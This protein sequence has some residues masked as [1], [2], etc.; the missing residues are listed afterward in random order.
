MVLKRKLTDKQKPAWVAE[1]TKYRRAEFKGI[2]LVLP[3]GFLCYDCIPPETRIGDLARQYDDGEVEVWQEYSFGWTGAP[4]CNECQ[5]AIPVYV[6][7]SGM[8]GIVSNGKTR[9]S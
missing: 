5:L 9:K 8:L 2:F 4:I 3:D 7:D 1:V 6:D